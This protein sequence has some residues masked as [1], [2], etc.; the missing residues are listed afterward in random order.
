MATVVD[1]RPPVLGPRLRASRATALPL[2][3][4]TTSMQ[5]A[6][7]EVHEVGGE[8]GV[9]MGVGP[10]EGDLVEAQGARPRRAGGV[11]HQG[12]AVLDDGAHDRGPAHAEV[13]GHARHRA[14]LLPDLAAG[15]GPGPRAS[16]T[17]GGRSR[18]SSARSSSPPRSRGRGNARCACD[19]T[20]TTRRPPA[21]RSRTRTRRRPLASARE[22]QPA[23]DHRRRR[24]HQLVQ[25][26]VD[27]GRRQQPETVH[28]HQ[29]DS[30][31]ATLESHQGPPRFLLAFVSRKNREAPGRGGG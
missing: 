5:P 21:G 6:P 2:R 1:A 9:A 14:V 12:S 15:L 24:L 30:A 28:A 17:P 4:A 7:F 31:V 16:S 23:A 19:H 20:T 26:A 29:R 10:Q 18:R 3:P 13:P 8:G 25:L 27:L 11:V 22:P